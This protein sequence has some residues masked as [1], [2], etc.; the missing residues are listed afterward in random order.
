MSSSIIAS[1]HQP[2]PSEVGLFD[3]PKKARQRSYEL[4]SKDYTA[5]EM[6]NNTTALYHI[7]VLV[8]PL[9]ELGQKWSSIIQVCTSFFFQILLANNTNVVAFKYTWCLHWNSLESWTLWRGTIVCLSQIVSLS[10]I[11]N[12]SSL[13]RDFIDTSS[14]Q[15]IQTPGVFSISISLN[16]MLTLDQERPS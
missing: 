7:A 3:T 8:D 14:P 11:V 1:S 9:S 4:L 15:R 16:Y 5:V 6:G 2:D 13:S 12:L 10:L